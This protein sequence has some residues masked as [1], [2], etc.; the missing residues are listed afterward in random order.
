MNKL[1]H[2]G[3]YFVRNLLELAQRVRTA[4]LAARVSAVSPAESL[5]WFN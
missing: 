1:P 4:A 3:D 5:A 2:E